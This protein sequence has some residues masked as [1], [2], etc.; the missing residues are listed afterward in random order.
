MKKYQ[1]LI[2]L[3]IS[4]F[5]LTACQP[6]TQTKQEITQIT[7]IV[8]VWKGSLS[9]APSN[10]EV[11]WAYYNTKLKKSFIYDGNSWQ[12]MSQD[13][14]DGTG[15]IWKGELSKAPSN[16]QKNWAYYNTTDGNSYIYN[17][18]VWNHLARAG[19]DGTSGVLLWMGSYSSK[20]SNPS[21][22]WAYY[23]T[24]EGISYIYNNGS[25]KVLSKDG[26]SIIW[27]GSLSKAPTTPEI[28]WAY[29]N[30]TTKTSYIWNG[31]SWN[32]LAVS[33]EGDTTVTVSIKWLGTY[34]SAPLNPQIGDAYYNSSTKASYVYDGNIWQQISKDG[35]NGTSAT[36][37]GYLITWKGSLSSEPQNPI[38][39][40]AYYNSS[41]K[42]SF[43]YD[44]TTWQIMAQD[45]ITEN[46]S[47][48]SENTSITSSIIYMGETTEIIDTIS[49]AVKSYAD[50]YAVEP[51]FYNYYKYYYLDGKLRRIKVFYHS[52]G[53]DLDYKYTEFVEHLCGS[54]YTQSYDYIYY[55]NGKLQSYTQNSNSNGINYKY[56]YYYDSDGNKSIQKNYQNGN[57][58]YEIQFYTNGKTKTQ[59]NYKVDV[60]PSYMYCKNTYYENGKEEYEINYSSDGAETSKNYYTYYESGNKKTYDSWRNGFKDDS[61]TYYDVASTTVKSYLDY[62][63]SNGLLYGESY[64]YSNGTKALRVYYHTD[65]SIDNFEYH[66]E[67]G[68]TQYYYTDS[69]YLYT[70]LDGKTTGTSTAS[71]VYSTKISYTE[72]QANT[73][74]AELKGN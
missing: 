53:S 56:E 66:F 58:Y 24:T 55:E 62:N 35:D 49:Y 16:P 43:I 3:F 61:Y 64:Y 34:T 67:S 47:T 73:K 20:P 45:G 4:I 26:K 54:N 39:G 71:N 6:T 8:P 51:Y 5:L 74:L 7:Y 19:K 46:T 22:G 69:G 68:Y 31:T 30:T 15:I 2:I 21:N 13:G 59:K 10:P 40:W 32:T 52:V 50:V 29:F 63:S 1:I 17:G 33:T 9:V 70:Y 36:I 23:N 42:K 27:K 11:G 65:G 57:L 18:S 72:E 37:S 12:I 38:A 41:E 25:W 28:N 60:Y 48:S 14:A 44:G